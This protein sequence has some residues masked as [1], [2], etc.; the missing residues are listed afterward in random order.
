MGSR[1]IPFCMRANLWNATDNLIQRL[2]G[3]LALEDIPRLCSE[4][5]RLASKGDC[6]CPSSLLLVQHMLAA[7]HQRLDA[8][9]HLSEQGAI[10]LK[11]F[12]DYLA[13]VVRIAS[14]R[15]DAAPWIDLASRFS[16]L[17]GPDEVAH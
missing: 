14:E 4:C 15:G 5:R 9:D 10:R 7:V 13:T 11:A 3:D 17:F 2:S 1:C 16:A 8:I 12:T 6:P